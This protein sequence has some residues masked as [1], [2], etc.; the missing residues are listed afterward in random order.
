MDTS[1]RG[2]SQFPNTT[3]DSVPIRASGGEDAVGECDVTSVSVGIEWPV[4]LRSTSERVSLTITTVKTAK[5]S[6]SATSRTEN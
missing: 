5:P 2:F 1:I 4:W 6:A 3:W